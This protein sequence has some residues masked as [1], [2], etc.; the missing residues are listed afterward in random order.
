MA[1]RADE[2]AQIR[3]DQVERY[4]LKDL[5]EVEASERERSRTTLEAI[6]DEIG[7]VVDAYPTWHPLVFNHPPREP[8]TTPGE[9]CGYRGLDH[10]RYFANGI[11]TCPYA[12]GGEVIDSVDALP[13]N[14]AAT[15]S[16]EKL[17]IHLYNATTTAI[18]IRCEWAKPLLAD[19]TIPASIAMPLLL[20]MEL[21]CW[22]WAKFGESWETMRPLFL[23]SPHGSR[24]SLFINQ[25]N[26]QKMK[27]AWEALVATEMYGPVWNDSMRA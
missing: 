26:G 15:I 21:P 12:D 11:I 10:T 5:K 19:G 24:S 25:E 7:P 8:I 9:H 20:E 6:I 18:L 14:F 1:F 2:A 3:R 13:E 17:D 4:F 27:R 22:R 23:G 16:A